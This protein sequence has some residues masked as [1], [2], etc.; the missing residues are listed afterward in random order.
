MSITTSAEL[1]DEAL[2]VI[3]AIWTADDVSFEGRHFTARGITAHPRPENLPPIWVGGN[4]AAA[5]QRVALYGDGWCPFAA[6]DMLARVTRT[7][8]M[9]SNDRLARG[10]ADLR[11]RCESAGRDFAA[12]DI[13]F[14]GLGAPRNGGG[15]VD[16]YSAEVGRLAALGVTALQ[17]SSPGDSLAHSLEMIDEFGGSI[18]AAHR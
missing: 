9:D 15:D 7:D 12:I 1:V 5:R 2:Q 16:A 13:V 4:T 17:V 10:I 3:R 14:N 18:I 11:R 8:A 6:P